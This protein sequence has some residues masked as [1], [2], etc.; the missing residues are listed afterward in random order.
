[1][2]ALKGVDV[3]LSLYEA[4]RVLAGGTVKLHIEP[5]PNA[6]R[7][8]TMHSAKGLEFPFVILGNLAKEFYMPELNADCLLDKDYGLAFKYYDVAARE[9][10]DTSLRVIVKQEHKKKLLEEEMRLLY[11]ALTRGVYQ[12]ALF[13]TPGEKFEPKQGQDAKGFLD[14]LYPHMEKRSLQC[15][16]GDTGFTG[17]K[18]ERMKPI[19]AESCR[20]FA[21]TQDKQNR[22]TLLQ[23]IKRNINFTY[24]YAPQTLKTTA[25]QIAAQSDVRQ[26]FD[27]VRSIPKHK[28]N[29][30]IE[31]GNACHIFLE[32][33]DFTLS[34]QKNVERFKAQYPQLFTVLAAAKINENKMLAAVRKIAERIAGRKHYQ[35]QPF[36]CRNSG[37][38]LIQ[39]VIDLL[40]IDPNG[41]EVIDYKTGIITSALKEQYTLQ[42][43]VYAAAAAQ[44][45]KTP[46]T[47]KSIFSLY[48]ISFLEV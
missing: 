28:S 45:L 11:V 30:G 5:P 17:N 32:S 2:D 7:I 10:R 43:N 42:A 9:R 18:D 37:G 20:P 29:A 25:T 8:M 1:L 22:N 40:I 19:G 27:D 12:V 21:Q 3:K 14:W 36:I 33:C 41:I 15:T 39:G 46:V 48:D 4:L 34:A 44:I 47:H 26:P 13:A 35:E 6:V 31:I 38:T 23:H 24:P 16:M